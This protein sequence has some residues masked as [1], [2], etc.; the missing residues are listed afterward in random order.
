MTI[1][2][3]AAQLLVDKLEGPMPQD[4]T[5]QFSVPIEQTACGTAGCAM[6][7]IAIDPE[8]QAAFGLHWGG[9]HAVFRD[10]NDHRVT[11]H[12]HIAAVLGIKPLI[13]FHIFYGGHPVYDRWR[14]GNM[15]HP[16]RVAAVIRHV[17]GLEEA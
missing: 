10:G 3:A 4:F 12:K 6:G 13:A 16:S 1:N 15:F 17:C 7:L 14:G 9:G 2:T 5:W 8:L 11:P